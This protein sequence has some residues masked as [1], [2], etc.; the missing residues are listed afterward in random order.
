MTTAVIGATAIPLML[1][2]TSRDPRGSRRGHSVRSVGPLAQRLVIAAA[3]APGS[4][5][6]G[7]PLPG[8]AR[9]GSTTIPRKQEP[10]AHLSTASLVLAASTT[11]GCAHGKPA[12][13]TPPLS[14]PGRVKTI[15][16]VHGAFADGS[17]WGKVIP[18]LEAG[19]YHVVSVQEPLSGLADDV[20]ATRR[21]IDLQTGP[22]LLVGHSW[23]GAVITEAGN[24]D[25]VA[26][27]VYVAAFVP[28]GGESVDD[29]GKGAPPAPWA[30]RLVVDGGGFA[31]LP[32]D[33][34]ATDFAPDLPPAESALVASVQQPIQTKAFGDKVTTA[35]WRSKRS[36][37]VR[38]EQDRMIDPG[39]QATMAARAGATV[40]NVKASHVS[41]LSRPTE[42]AAAIVAAAS[43]T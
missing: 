27:L 18:L 2:H 8:T 13:S 36:W 37:Y 24:H 34:V 14:T 42:V 11:I 23:G 35:A 25:K 12:E 9:A 38:S 41:M 21:A 33:V 22:V 26:G 4:A 3:G 7:A 29:L 10:M 31:W 17:S 1:A 43:A 39:A 19:G 16:L 30:A 15:V 6:A 32:A 28:D 5:S 40:T 20:A